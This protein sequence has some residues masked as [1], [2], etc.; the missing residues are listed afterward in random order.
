MSPLENKA[1]FAEE[2]AGD[3]SKEGCC[4]RS[5]RMCTW[6][7]CGLL[8][9]PEGKFRRTWDNIVCFAVLY[10]AFFLPVE[11]SFWANNLLKLDSETRPL[12][13]GASTLMTVVFLL[14]ILFETQTARYDSVSGE[15]ITDRKKLLT[16]Y[17]LRPTGFFFDFFTS[18][19]FAEVSASCSV[20]RGNAS[21]RTRLFLCVVWCLVFGVR[22]PCR[23]PTAADTAVAL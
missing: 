1:P 15:L 6:L 5:C 22:V 13:E 23:N 16:I 3:A 4:K 20:S 17:F 7:C 10:I 9:H 18:F 19:P 21:A 2:F 11:I 12:V 8:L 14:D